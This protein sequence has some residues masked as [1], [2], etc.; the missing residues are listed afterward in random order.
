MILFVAI[1]LVGL[2]AATAGALAGRKLTLRELPPRHVLFNT[3]GAVGR[4]NS[5]AAEVENA[6][7]P[8]V[9]A[10]LDNAESR[11]RTFILAAQAAERKA[12]DTAAGQAALELA[13]A[14]HFGIQLRQPV[15]VVPVPMEEV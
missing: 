3:A 14:Q 2:L 13:V 5:A 12:G 10:R 4:A 8:D 6:N 7:L 9:L 15:A 11:I 1:L